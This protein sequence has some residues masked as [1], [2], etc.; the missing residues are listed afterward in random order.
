MGKYNYVIFGSDWDLYL[1]AYSDVFEM[2]DAR[3]IKPFK[4]YNLPCGTLKKVAFD[5][6]FNP[7]ANRLFSIPFKS[8]WNKYYFI[9]DFKEDKPICFIFFNNWVKLENDLVDYLKYEYPGSKF[10]WF[11]QDLIK[12]QRYAFSRK[13]YDVDKIKREFDL[14]MS[15][16]YAD[17]QKYDMVYHPL[18]YSSSNQEKCELE[19]DVYFLGQAKTRLHEII[20]VYE[21]LKRQGIR[22]SFYIAGAPRDQRQYS[23]EIHYIRRMDYETNLY[24]IR[25]SKCLLELMQESADNFTIRTCEAIGLDKKLITNSPVI[26]SQHFYRKDYITKI[27]MP[28]DLCDIDIKAFLKDID[29]VDYGNKEQISPSEFFSFIDSHL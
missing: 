28:S 3:Y 23:N 17:C 7:K 4:G 5:F 2:P 8:Y 24:H 15:F 25:R 22:C 21:I 26:T 6:H 27:Q 1:H 19:S 10:V 20:E 29:K 16:D 11:N 14:C 9:D 12:T 13:K 18:V